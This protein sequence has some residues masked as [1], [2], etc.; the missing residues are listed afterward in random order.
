MR[1]D[2]HPV[3]ELRDLPVIDRDGVRCGVIDEVLFEGLPGKP[4]RIAAI[5]IGPGAWSERLPGWAMVLVR[6]LAGSRRTTIVWS[7]VE[8][9][10]GHVS[11][12]RSASE[13]GLADAER[14]LAGPLS[15][16]PFG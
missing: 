13:L 4:L 12:K 11:L 1:V 8:R 7:E 6:A 9:V 2:L 15:K 16:V 3:R 14:R 10:T 5:Q